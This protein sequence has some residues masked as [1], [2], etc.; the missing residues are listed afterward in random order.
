MMDVSISEN[1]D[2]KR[3]ETKVE[4]K[5]AFIE[6]IRA[7]ESVYLTHTEVPKELEGKGI[8]SSMVKQVLIQIKEE[9][10]KLVP[11]CPF[12]AAYVKRHPEWKEILAK[13]YNV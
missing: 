5:T 12:V 8:A 6:Y 7:Q 10:N 1:K 2:K 11:L 3:F 13:G 4:G 9:G